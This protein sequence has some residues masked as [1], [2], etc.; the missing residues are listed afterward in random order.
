M[1]PRMLNYS[2]PYPHMPN[3]ASHYP[4]K[5]IK[6]ISNTSENY[7]EAYKTAS[8]QYSEHYKNLP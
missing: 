8:S 4:P 1:D 7:K 2:Y 6:P 5:H 3:Y